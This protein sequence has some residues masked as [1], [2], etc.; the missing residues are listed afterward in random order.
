[1]RTV[2][3][4]NRGKRKLTFVLLHQ[5]VCV[6]A[7]KCYCSDGKP[8]ALHLPA[9]VAMKRIPASVKYCSD[10]ISHK[11]ISITPTPKQVVH[12]DKSEANEDI[13]GKGRSHRKGKKK[14]QTASARQDV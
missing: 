1:M 10:L 12:K 3:I 7:G 6:K 9:G 4:L 2:T 8:G 14:Q 5:E 13:S 11:S